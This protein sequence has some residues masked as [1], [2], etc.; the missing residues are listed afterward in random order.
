M[1]LLAYTENYAQT[2]RHGDLHKLEL[3]SQNDTQDRLITKHQNHTLQWRNTKAHHKVIHSK[4]IHSYSH[5]DTNELNETYTRTVFKSELSCALSHP[6]DPP[7]VYLSP[8]DFR[9]PRGQRPVDILTHEKPNLSD[10]GYKWRMEGHF[11][12]QNLY[13]DMLPFSVGAK[14]RL[15]S[16]NK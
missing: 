1:K 15:S 14:H 2:H 4:G 8:S 3:K 13:F 9:K 10:I 16:T 11:A 12:R 5:A 7:L 6:W